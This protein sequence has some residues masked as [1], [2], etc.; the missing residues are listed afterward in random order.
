MYD[1]KG[2]SINKTMAKDRYKVLAVEDKDN[3]N[4][5]MQAMAAAP[6]GSNRKVETF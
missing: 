5:G 4:N 6:V 3:K 2:D 1:I